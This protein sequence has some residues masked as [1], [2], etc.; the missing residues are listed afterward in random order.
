VKG[1]PITIEV[2]VPETLMHYGR[3]D[4]V[5]LARGVALALEQFWDAGGDLHGATLDFEDYEL[6][7]GTG[8]RVIL[9]GF[10]G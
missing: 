2:K 4:A 5:V 7:E 6:E 8:T 9:M 3:G 10:E 1:R